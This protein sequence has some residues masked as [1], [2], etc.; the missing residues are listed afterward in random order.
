MN[1]I[2]LVKANQRVHES[3]FGEGWFQDSKN[4]HHP[5]YNQWKLC[6]YFIQKNGVPQYPDDLDNLV[7][8]A[9]VI[10]DT[11]LWISATQGNINQILLGTIKNYG[12]IRVQKQ[13]KTQIGNPEKYLDILVEISFGMWNQMKGY[14][15]LPLEIEGPDFMI[16]I[17]GVSIPI[18][19]ECKNLG[20]ISEKSIKSKVKKINTQ[21]KS[22][23]DEVYGVG[24]IDLSKAV[25]LQQ[26]KHKEFP[27]EIQLARDIT[28]KILHPGQYRSVISIYLT[29]DDYLIVGNPPERTC[30]AIR[31]RCVQVNHPAPRNKPNFDPELFD[32]YTVEIIFDWSR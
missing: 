4:D 32:G 2:E 25:L 1:Q 18:Y 16:E 3:L 7:K 24:F 28:K 29:W 20:N 22:I 31:K 26:N 14:K 27:A 23:S 19:T 30:V 15:V 11:S 10:F 12:D 17:P 8:L 13:I 21:I 6:S 5:A 9:K